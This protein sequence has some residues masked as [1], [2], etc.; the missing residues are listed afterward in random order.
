[1]PKFKHVF[2]L[3]RHWTLRRLTGVG[4]C[5]RRGYGVGGGS[6]GGEKAAAGLC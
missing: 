1:M 3:R 5:E 4:V 2:D 6:M